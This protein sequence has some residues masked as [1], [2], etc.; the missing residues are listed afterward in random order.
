MARSSWRSRRSFIFP[1]VD[2]RSCT[3]TWSEPTTRTPKRLKATKA[4]SG[5]HRNH[6][7]KREERAPPSITPGPGLRSV[8]DN[9]TSHTGQASTQR[10]S[11]SMQ[12]NQQ[13]GQEKLSTSLVSTIP[14]PKARGEYL[15]NNPSGTHLHLSAQPRALQGSHDHKTRTCKHYER[16]SPLLSLQI[17]SSIK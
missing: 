15:P 16:L 13:R 8:L 1:P 11:L 14:H 12:P 7:Q 17:P 3:V 10:S 9:C 4:K 6:H 2:C 5:A